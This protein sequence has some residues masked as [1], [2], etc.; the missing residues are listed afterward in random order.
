MQTSLGKFVRG[1]TEVRPT[2]GGA[3]TD[4]TTSMTVTVRDDLSSLLAEEAVHQPLTRI[5]RGRHDDRAP[6]NA[7]ALGGLHRNIAPPLHLGAPLGPSGRH[8]DFRFGSAF[9]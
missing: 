8:P 3:D 9:N 6:P 1:G 4:G 7:T 2:L 5:S